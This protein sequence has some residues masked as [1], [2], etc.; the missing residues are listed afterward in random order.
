MAWSQPDRLR[1]TLLLRSHARRGG[2]SGAYPYARGPRKLPVVFSA[3][4]VVLFLEAVSTLK[5]RAALTT[6]YADHGTDVFITLSAAYRRKMPARQGFIG[7][8]APD[9]CTK[10]KSDP[11]ANRHRPAAP[12]RRRNSGAASCR[13]QAGNSRPDR[14]RLG[15]LTVAAIALAPN[16][17]DARNRRKER[18]A[19]PCSGKNLDRGPNICK[20]WV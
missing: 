9:A 11:S 14:N 15:S 2:R 18:Q 17:S 4:E 12:C 1:L 13:S 8:I 19:H 6:A 5:S 3:D 16:D 7:C 10:S 20:I